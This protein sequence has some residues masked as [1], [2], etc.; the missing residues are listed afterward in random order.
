MRSRAMVMGV[1]VWGS[2]PG[3][4]GFREET[5]FVV[6]GTTQAASAAPVCAADAQC[7]KGLR[8]E[9]RGGASGSCAP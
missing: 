2:S 5:F 3:C 7:P 4:D 1:M 8:C 9:L 6:G